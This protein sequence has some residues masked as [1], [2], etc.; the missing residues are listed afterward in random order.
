MQH[1]CPKVQP[2]LQVDRY[3]YVNCCSSLWRRRRLQRITGSSLATTCVALVLQRRGK[4]KQCNNSQIC[5]IHV[6]ENFLSHSHINRSTLSYQIKQEPYFQNPSFSSRNLQTNVLT[7]YRVMNWPG[8][9]T[10]NL[11][12]YSLDFTGIDCTTVTDSLA[13]CKQKDKSF[14]R[15]SGLLGK[16]TCKQTCN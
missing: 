8:K 6:Q 15:Q 13:N 12:M 7:T 5:V 9:Q 16:Q 1:Y 14:N 4:Q 11:F 10:V 2:R 3:S